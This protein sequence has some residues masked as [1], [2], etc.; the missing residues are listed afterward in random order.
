MRECGDGVLP[1][2]EDL[3]DLE[4]AVGEDIPDHI[5]G[6]SQNNEA[7]VRSAEDPRQAILSDASKLVVGLLTR[8]ALL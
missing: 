4:E 8:D 5:R 7:M 2:S 3:P 6:L 1:E